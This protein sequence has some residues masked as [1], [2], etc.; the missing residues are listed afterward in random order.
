MIQH[1]M[2]WNYK[3]DVMSEQRAHIEAE[4]SALPSRIPSLQGVAYGPVVGGRNQTFDHCFVMRF[5]GSQDL[6]DYTVHPEHQKF[7]AMF[8]EACAVQVVADFEEVSPS[9]ELG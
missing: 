3:D 9:H 5:S 2:L 7:A 8:R 4:L 6:A 1:V